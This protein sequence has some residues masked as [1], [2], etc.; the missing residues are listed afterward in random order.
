MALRRIEAGCAFP[1][2]E[3]QTTIRDVARKAIAEFDN[4]PFES[5]IPAQFGSSIPK[6]YHVAKYVDEVLVRA[7]RECGRDL[8]HDS[9]IRGGL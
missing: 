2:D 7:C 6:H 5:D 9:H 3:V 4:K 8:Q 1:S